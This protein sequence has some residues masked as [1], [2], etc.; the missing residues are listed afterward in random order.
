MQHCNITTQFTN[1][2]IQL[3]YRIQLMSPG[4][5][6]A[7]LE[8]KWGNMSRKSGGTH[9]RLNFC[10]IKCYAFHNME[11]CSVW[12][13]PEL[14]DAGRLFIFLSKLSESCGRI[15]FPF[16]ACVKIVKLLRAGLLKMKALLGMKSLH[17]KM[18][19]IKIFLNIRNLTRVCLI[20][21]CPETAQ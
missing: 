19:N 9:H 6:N 3:F 14:T 21:S 13:L 2:F 16:C 8:I 1:Y 20:F 5:A 10:L 18:Q 11:L 12:K 15:I 17:P 4:R 7:I